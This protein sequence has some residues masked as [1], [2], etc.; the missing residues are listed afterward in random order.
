[1]VAE[2]AAS[3]NAEDPVANVQPEG[4]RAMRNF[5]DVLQQQHSTTALD[6]WTDAA[7]RQSGMTGFVHP[8]HARAEMAASLDTSSAQ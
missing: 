7:A 3:L 4:A 6:E 8:T 1:M 2:L 5:A